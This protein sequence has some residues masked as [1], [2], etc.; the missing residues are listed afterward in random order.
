MKFD[1][2]FKHVGETNLPN[3]SGTRI[4]MMPIIIGDLNSIPKE[5]SHYQEGLNKLFSFT[6]PKHHGQIGY[7]T[8]D[9]KQVLAGTTHRRSGLHVDG[10][11]DGK[12]GSWGGGGWGS[13][14]NGMLTVS[15]IPGC[16]AYNQSFDG[17][18]GR[19][20]ECD[21]IANQC[22]AAKSTI[23]E[24]GQV[25]WVDGLC[26]HESLP[27]SQTTN[28]QFVRLSMP[29]TAPW[30]KGYSENPLGIKPTGPI[31]SRRKQMNE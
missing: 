19:D 6:D 14:G 4:M 5:L 25:Y 23:F 3:F 15:S 10:V 7:I 17:E 24:A 1:S 18:I 16:K 28:R 20:G 2:V 9:E 11:Y 29:S 21:K 31:L 12:C 26:V 22:E 13:V 27:L 8:I 30:F